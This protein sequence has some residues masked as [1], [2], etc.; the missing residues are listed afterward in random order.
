MKASS[1]INMF[2]IFKQIFKLKAMPLVV[3]VSLVF[4]RY[5]NSALKR[6]EAEIQ[7]PLHQ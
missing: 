1:N 5:M 7:Q 2:K 4:G 3:A 6:E